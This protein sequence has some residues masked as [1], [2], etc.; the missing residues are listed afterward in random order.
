MTRT[1]PC[2]FAFD[3]VSSTTLTFDLVH[4]VGTNGGKPPQLVHAQPQKGMRPER[5]DLDTQSNRDRRRM[6]A[7]GSEAFQ[8][9]SLGG[10]LIEMEGLGIELRR[11]A[12][13]VFARNQL[14]GTLQNN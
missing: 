8:W 6:P 7:G 10:R 14:I 11:K 13:D 5:A 12:L 2:G 9:R 1:T 4:V 3:G